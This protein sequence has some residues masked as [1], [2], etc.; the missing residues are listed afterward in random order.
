[1]KAQT[2]RLTAAQKKAMLDEIKRETVEVVR[3]YET[4]QDA[5]W[6]LAC[7]E[8]YGSGAKVLARLY[9]RYF[10][11]R[12]KVQADYQ[13]VEG[14]GIRETAMKHKLLEVGVDVDA[15]YAQFG[16]RRHVI[17]YKDEEDKK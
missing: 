11:L 10:D 15:L 14:D 3:A 8:E 1:M 5:A 13:G 2:F 4:D 12:R 7:R 16:E 6:L 17:A 9:K